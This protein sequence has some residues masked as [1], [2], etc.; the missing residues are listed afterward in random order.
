[1]RREKGRK[2]ERGRNRHHEGKRE[3]ERKEK[4]KEESIVNTPNTFTQHIFTL[5]QNKK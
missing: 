3:R 5:L 2:E 1:L 4:R